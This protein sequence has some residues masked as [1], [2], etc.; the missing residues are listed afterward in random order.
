MYVTHTCECLS[1]WISGEYGNHRA[2]QYEE[3]APDCEVDP[4]RQKELLKALHE[5][6]ATDQIDN[7]L[8]EINKLDYNRVIEPV[9]LSLDWPDDDDVITR[10]EAE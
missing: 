7:I 1:M 2:A 9:P 10:I 5:F 8:E 3:N 4:Q 6:F